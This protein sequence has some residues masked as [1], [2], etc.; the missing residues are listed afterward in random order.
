M[1]GIRLELMTITDVQKRYHSQTYDNLNIHFRNNKSQ[2]VTVQAHQKATP[3]LKKKEHT[4]LNDN[5]YVLIDKLQTLI[6]LR[7][8]LKEGMSQW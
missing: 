6:R 1:D 2:D 8:T 3:A 4:S 5:D 7:L